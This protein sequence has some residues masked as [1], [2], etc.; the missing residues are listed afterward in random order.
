MSVRTTCYLALLV[1]SAPFSKALAQSYRVI[2]LGSRDSGGTPVPSLSTGLDSFGRVA[3]SAR[4]DGGE[5]AF[6]WDLG[7]LGVENETLGFTSDTGGNAIS[8]HG[9]LVGWAEVDNPSFN[10]AVA[11]IGGRIFDLGTLGGIASEALA[12]NRNDWIVGWANNGDELSHGFVYH[13]SHMNDIGTLPGGSESGAGAINSFGRVAGWSRDANGRHNAI[14]WENDLML[15]L[16]TLPGDRDS[17]A[18]GMNDYDQVVGTSD[19]HAFLFE[20]DFTGGTMTPLPTFGGERSSA[21]DINNSGVIVGTAEPAQGGLQACIWIDRQPVDLNQLIA[22]QSGWT[23]NTPRAIN[24]SGYISALATR[25]GM[26]RGVL[27]VPTPMHMDPPTP[28]RT[29]QVNTFVAT[30]ATPGAQV[31]LLYGTQSGFSHPPGCP[32]AI[33]EMA[34]SLGAATTVADQDGVATFDLFVPY[35]ARGRIFIVQMIEPAECSLSQPLRMTF[36]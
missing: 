3:G 8:D 22:P 30:G 27:L 9:V 33:V 2:D 15:S 32:T 21:L 19:Q 35:L 5:R 28:A 7:T 23:I 29:G 20:G 31:R 16:G 13:N 26:E 36:R 6:V 11:W 1:C 4:G 14:I 25:D 18:T 34:Q 17:F 12:I 10:H 24:E